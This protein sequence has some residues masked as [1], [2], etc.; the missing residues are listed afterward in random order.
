MILDC[1]LSK[2]IVLLSQY[3]IVN[4]NTIVS[5]SL[6]MTIIDAFTYLQKFNIVF[7]CLLVLSD[8]IVKDTD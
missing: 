5:Q 1:F 6:S 2:L 7:N 3:L 8:V 4:T